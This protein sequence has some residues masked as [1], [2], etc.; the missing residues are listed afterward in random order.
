MIIV[1]YNNFLIKL[2]NFYKEIFNICVSF[3]LSLL[4]YL[5]YTCIYI[6]CC[7]NTNILI[8]IYNPNLLILEK[9]LIKIELAS[10][11]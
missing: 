8:F 1:I 4:V 7:I 5:F 9:Y 2:G 10:P 6:L 3:E 11:S